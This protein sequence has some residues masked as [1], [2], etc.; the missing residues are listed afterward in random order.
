MTEQ[1]RKIKEELEKE[2]NSH[3]Q[4]LLEEKKANARMQAE[5][6]NLKTELK[7]I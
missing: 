5:L 4:T 2:I 3:K 6:Q 1:Q 7:S